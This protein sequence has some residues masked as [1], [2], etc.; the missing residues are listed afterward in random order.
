MI[1]KI[2][3]GTFKIVAKAIYATPVI[4]KP[5]FN[6]LVFF[7]DNLFKAIKRLPYVIGGIFVLWFALSFFGVL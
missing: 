7:F 4:G 6:A 3:G 1:G 5:I 2:L